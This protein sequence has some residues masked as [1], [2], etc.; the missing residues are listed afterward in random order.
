MCIHLVIK[1]KKNS[2]A[3]V[4]EYKQTALAR[5]SLIEHHFYSYSYFCFY[6]FVFGFCLLVSE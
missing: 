4:Q 5:K 6:F 1:L 3:Q 2:M